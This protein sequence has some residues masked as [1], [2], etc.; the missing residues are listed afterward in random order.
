[1]KYNEKLEA[2]IGFVEDN[3]TNVKELVEWLELTI[4]DVV[5]CFPDAL[6]NSYEKVFPLD[7]EEL[8]DLSEA[9]ELVAWN[10]VEVFG[11]FNPME[12]LLDDER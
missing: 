3:F 5:Q 2:M 6:V 7:L 8:D 4:E 9:E 12:D 1:M 10:G 11:M